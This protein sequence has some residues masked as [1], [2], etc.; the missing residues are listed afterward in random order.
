VAQEFTQGDRVKWNTPQD[1]TYGK[2]KKKLTSTTEVGGQKVNASEDD[3]R[4][5]IESEKS[6]NEAAHKPDSLS[7]A[8]RRHTERWQTTAGRPSTS[9]TTP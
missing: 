4:Y 2:V 7:K 1:E 3:P 5:L 9:S 6:S 8:W